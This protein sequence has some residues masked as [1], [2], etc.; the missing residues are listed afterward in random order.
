MRE[1]SD[2]GRAFQAA[3]EQ[4]GYQLVTGERGLL[5]LDSAGKEHSL[6][7]RSG[8][9]MKELNAFMRDVDRAALPTVEQA[10]ELYQERKIAGLEADRET[11]RH[12][13]EWEEALARSAIEKEKIEGRFI[14]PEDRE[15]EARAGQ[16]QK[17]RAAREWPMQPPQPEPIKTSPR[18]HFGDAAREAGRET[19]AGG[20]TPKPKPRSGD[21]RIRQAEQPTAKAFAGE[22]ERHGLAFARVTAD[23]AARSHREAEF[24]KTIGNY[25]PR[26]TEGEIVAVSEPGLQYHRD[27]QWKEP[28]RVHRLDPANAGKYL[29]LLSLDKK[30]LPGIEAA[31]SML[32]ARAGQ[33]AADW[34]AIRQERATTIN[35][36][37]PR[38]RS[39]R[40]VKAPKIMT[41]APS[42]VFG[43][44]GK[45]LDIVSGIF[46]SIFAPKLTPQQIREGERAAAKREAEA[47]NNTDFAS[48]IAQLAQERQNRQGE[49]AARARQ[50]EPE[51]DH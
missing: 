8:M 30:P 32:D 20:Q 13:I 43:A 4:H 51:R 15:R 10:K 36:Q 26:F 49:E 25:A 28:P 33:R 6:A 46:E 9:T 17:E 12:E 35:D 22:L 38:G 21:R 42:L 40:Q 47:E 37:A 5:I 24:A 29:A 1:Q 18:H 23:E 7:K 11:V 44:V 27:G 48:H 31:K 2:T 45:S 14:A 3:L 16:K 50:R 41:A 19:R 39:A 34:Q